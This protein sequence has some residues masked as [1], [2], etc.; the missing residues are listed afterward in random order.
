[1]NAMQ[2]K[3]DDKILSPLELKV[4][5]LAQ[6]GIQRN[7]I[8]V[9]L[10]VS[11]NTVKTV[12][13]RINQK[14]GT[15]WREQP[16]GPADGTPSNAQPERPTLF[17]PPGNANQEGGGPI[18]RGVALSMLVLSSRPRT[19]VFRVSGAQRFFLRPALHELADR[20]YLRLLKVDWYDVYQPEWLPVV[21]RGRRSVRAANYITENGHY[22][23]GF[24]YNYL[25]TKLEEYIEQLG[26]YLQA[27]YRVNGSSSRPVNLPTIDQLSAYARQSF[28]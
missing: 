24:L 4:A 8:A 17:E 20:K 10:G 12:L 22:V 14:L 28:G 19:T 26:M 5:R 6:S 15:G 18:N 1:M 3:V 9:S 21:N 25:E 27:A 13:L 23:Q 11:A 7:G 2:K 16:L